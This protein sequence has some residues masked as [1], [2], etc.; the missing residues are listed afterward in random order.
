MFRPKPIS[1]A[2]IEAAFAKAERYRLLN[3]PREAESISLDILATAPGDQRALVTL[4]LS[5]TDQ[6]KD[7]LLPN[8]RRAQ[9]LLERLDGEYARYYYTGIIT[10]R[11]AKVL[12]ANDVGCKDRRV[13]DQLKEAMHWYE[14]AEA[15]RPPDDEDSI[16]RWNACGRIVEARLEGMSGEHR[17][18]DLG[19]FPGK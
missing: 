5:I 15:V 17:L 1:Q 8:V 6:F 7:D 19:I 2:T 14:K 16:L 13:H 10:E 3:E 12:L 18:E 4:L 11:W 9:S